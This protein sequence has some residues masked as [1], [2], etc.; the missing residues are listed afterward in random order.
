MT[1]LLGDFSKNVGVTTSKTTDGTDL[2][3]ITLKVKD[4][5]E[6]LLPHTGGPG[7]RE[8]LVFA[9][10]MLG[11]AVCLTMITILRQREVNDHD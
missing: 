4:S 10:C 2:T 3:T 11:I 1:T 9:L 6:S 7:D 5:P 8:Y